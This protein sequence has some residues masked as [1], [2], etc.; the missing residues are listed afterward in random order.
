LKIIE[1]K[2][3]DKEKIEKEFQNRLK[4]AD[5]NVAKEALEKKDEILKKILESADLKEFYEDVKI[6]FRMIKDYFNGRCNLP[7]GTI[8]AIGVALLYVLSPL[9]VIPDFIP[10][11]GLLD[12]AL[13]L[14]LCLKLIKD[15]IEEYKKKCLDLVVK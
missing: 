9:D 5:E 3:M 6:F 1:G 4:N 7:V 11:V 10:V 8:I 15:D 2:R 14:N 12:D 13:V